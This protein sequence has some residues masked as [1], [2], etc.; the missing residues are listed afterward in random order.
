[1]LLV[2]CFWKTSVLIK[3]IFVLFCLCLQ[4]ILLEM[5]M[6]VVV[7]FCEI[8]NSFNSVS[9]ISGKQLWVFACIFWGL[10][11]I[12]YPFLSPSAQ[13]LK[14]RYP[15][16]DS[17]VPTTRSSSPLH[18]GKLNLK[19]IAQNMILLLYFL[20]GYKIVVGYYGFTLVVLVFCLCVHSAII[21]PSVFSFLNNN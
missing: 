15:A 20:P 12:V 17:C 11:F 8:H 6:E 9:F 4:L 2:L 16:C 21:C 7:A 3:L 18:I 19:F 14:T 5:M 10:A 1:M 13:D